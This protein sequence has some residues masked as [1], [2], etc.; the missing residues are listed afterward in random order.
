[1]IAPL[2]QVEVKDMTNTMLAL[3]TFL[4]IN[5]GRG[6]RPSSGGLGTNID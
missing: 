1:M 2:I 3:L 5:A 6:L 4:F